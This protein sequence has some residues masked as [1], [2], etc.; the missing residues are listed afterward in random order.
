MTIPVSNV[1]NE[2]VDVGS[3]SRNMAYLYGLSDFFSY[4]FEDTETLNLMLEAGAV[5][6]SDIYSKFLQLTTSISLADI[7]EQIGATIKLLIISES[8]QVGS[9]PVYSISQP[10]AKAKFLS[11]RPFLPTELLEENV[12]F[13][14]IQQDTV[15]SI[16]KFARP[17]EEYKF[18]KRPSLDGSTEYA[19]WV[20]DVAID[21]QMMYKNFGKILGVTPEVSSEQFSNFVYGLYYLYL[22]GPTLKVMEQGLNLVLGVPLAR[23]N[24][25]ILD[26]QRSI[27]EDRYIVITNVNQY[28]IPRGIPPIVSIGEE[29]QVGSVLAKWIELKDYVSD[30]NWWINVSVPSTIIRTKPLS[31]VDRFA[32]TGSFYDYLMTNYLKNNTFLIRINVGTFETNKYFNYISDII[33]KSKPA[34]SQPIYVWRLDMGEDEFNTIEEISFTTTQVASSMSSINSQPIDELAI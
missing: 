30:G 34:H 1:T 8:N 20:T 11:N 12:D 10:L 4:I 14:I 6:A 26:I 32:R 15:S 16:V 22:N 23:E 31:Q 2:G 19:V 13:K 7:Q 29:V 9:L 27:E 17:I 5:S 25:K 18:S 28:L 3:N 33:Y 21:E 24:E